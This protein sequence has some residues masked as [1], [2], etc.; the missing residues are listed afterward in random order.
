MHVTKG[1]TA[2]VTFEGRRAPKTKDA[3]VV[4]NMKTVWAGLDMEAR[5]DVDIAAKMAAQEESSVIV[6]SEKAFFGAAVGVEGE[7]DLD[8]VTALLLPRRRTPRTDHDVVTN[9]NRNPAIMIKDTFASCPHSVTKRK[10]KNLGHISTMNENT[11]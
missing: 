2:F 7:T 1:W 8:V 3:S 5:L 11:E 4:N 10:E 9:V 6:N